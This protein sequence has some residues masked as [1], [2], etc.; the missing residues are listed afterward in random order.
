[1]R[2][3]QALFDNPDDFVARGEVDAAYRDALVRFKAGITHC[4]ISLMR[5]RGG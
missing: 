5:I 4:A 2:K 3:A 1:V